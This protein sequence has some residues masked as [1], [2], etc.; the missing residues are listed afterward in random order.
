MSARVPSQEELKE[1]QRRR[2]A[3]LGE[4][5]DP[6]RSQAVMPKG[7]DKQM[8]LHLL[9]PPDPQPEYFQEE[10]SAL[11]AFQGVLAN[12]LQDRERL[13]NLFTAWSSIPKYNGAA[14]AGKSHSIEE[15]LPILTHKFLHDGDEFEMVLTPAQLKEEIDGKE[16][17]SF[18]YPGLT[19]EY[20]EL[21]LVKMA[22]EEAQLYQPH[23]KGDSYSYGASFSLNGLRNFMS[24]QKKSRTYPEMVRSLKILNKCNLEVVINGV[25]TAS[26]PILSE[27]LTHTQNGYK[28]SDPG[29]RWSVR[30]HPLISMSINNRNYRQYNIERLMDTKTRAALSLSKMLLTHARNLSA[31]H[32][33]RIKYTDFVK[34]CGELNYARRSDGIRKFIATGESL[35]EF[36]TLSAVKVHRIYGTRKNR[37][38]DV[39]LQLFGSE[40]LIREIKA[41]HVKEKI[42]IEQYEKER[43]K[44]EMKEKDS[45]KNKSRYRK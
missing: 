11:R 31:E 24:S 29:S 42:V 45:M 3:L 26:A 13:S 32:P 12:K 16:V 19:E 38:V 41:G 23:R 1:L 40:S 37:V 9:D 15:P 43:L 35:K 28:N 25:S 4:D 27:M 17:T 2:Q 10:H 34:H 14:L 8:N 7:S 39:E 30:F 5:C 44:L 21:A 33:F 18:Y 22:M 6:P 36:G 20:V